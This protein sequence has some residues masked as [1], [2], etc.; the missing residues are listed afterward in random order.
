MY[1]L[2]L[3]EMNFHKYLRMNVCNSHL[4]KSFFPLNALCK[5]SIIIMIYFAS[6][7]LK[8]GRGYWT[9]VARIVQISVKIAR[10]VRYLTLLK[11]V[12]STF[13]KPINVTFQIP[14][15]HPSFGI[16]FTYQVREKYSP[17]FLFTDKFVR[18]SWCHSF[19]ST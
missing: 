9:A 3:F 6:Q 11:V 4:I 19:I 10:Q 8:G 17:F 14:Q 13:M 18:K 2:M 1:F 15:Y 12:S 7:S 16:V 5:K